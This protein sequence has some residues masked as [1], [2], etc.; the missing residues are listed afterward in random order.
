MDTESPKKVRGYYLSQDVMDWVEREAV[1]EERSASWF[2]DR[3][4]RLMMNGEKVRKRS[5]R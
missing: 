2:L 3:L 1:M 5:A 4:L